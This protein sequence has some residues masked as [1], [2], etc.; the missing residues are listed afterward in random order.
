MK[1]FKQQLT[2][3]GTAFSSEERDQFGLRGLLPAKVETLDL[4][5]QRCILQIRTFTSNLE[6]YVYLLSLKD[7]NETLFYYVLTLHM[8]ELLP[9]VYTPT[10]GEACQKFGTIWRTSQG[11]YF[12]VE[13]K[14]AYRQMLDNWH[15]TPDI[16]GK[17]V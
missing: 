1:Q 11:M 16:I 5:A 17:F 8:Q 10:V 14:G 15:D 2:F 7:R 6:K 13:D 9:I 12:S 4:Q 3:P